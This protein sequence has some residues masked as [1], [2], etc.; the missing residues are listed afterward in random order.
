[1]K[2]HKC[3]NRILVTLAFFIA[4]SNSF[5]LNCE[6]DK[7]GW[8]D[9]IG[10]AFTCKAKNLNITQPKTL[11]TLLKAQPHPAGESNDNVNTFLIFE[12]ICDYFP[13]GIEK[14][15]KNLE[16][17][18]V[19]KSG[20]KRITKSD[21]KPF[22]KLK[23]ISLY[24]NELTT[25]ES[26]LFMYNPKLKLISVFNNKLKHVYP[27]ILDGLEH[28][29]RVYFSSNPCF[30]EDGVNPEK[31]EQLKCKLI[32]SCPVTEEMIQYAEIENEK[33]KI[34]AENDK[35]KESL[36]A[37]AKN[38]IVVKRKFEKSQENYILLK[39]QSSTPNAFICA[40]L[41][42]DLATCESEKM[43]LREL[44]QE[45]EV[46]ELVCDVPVNSGGNECI[47]SDL[48][49]L[50][51]HIK[52]VNIRRK[53]KRLLSFESMNELLIVDQ[54]TLFLPLNISKFLPRLAQL[55]VTRSELITINEE[56]FIGLNDLI[57][58]D[59]SQ[60]QLTEVK[61]ENFE[62]LVKLQKLD[63]SGN[64]IDFIGKRA[65]NSLVNLVELRLNDNKLTILGSKFF[66]HNKNLK[67][68]M[69]H[70]NQLN[71]IASNFL[72]T[73][74]SHL[75]NLDMSNN[76]CIDLKYPDVLLEYLT[77]HFTTKCIVEIDFE[78]RFES[79]FDY[80]CHAENVF[81]ET[82]NV[83]VV[84]II[85]EHRLNLSNKDVTALKIVNQTLEVIPYNLGN[86]LPNLQSV[87]IESS[88]LS[89]I[90]KENFEGL[91]NIKQLTIKGN[92][93]K[94]IVDATF[95]GFTQLQVLDLSFNCIATLAE[96]IFENLTTLKTLNLSHNQLT[97]L[98]AWMIPA[99]NA[100]EN[101]ICSQNQLT[102]IDPRL[103]RRLKSVRLLDFEDNKCIN[104]KFDES[105]HSERKVME[106]FGEAA[107]KC[108]D[109]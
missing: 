11:I 44:I 13:I 31:V 28:L 106:M 105:Q 40:S 35:L 39:K 71:Q 20:L 102:S 64:K 58:L 78:C 50:K 21:L 76:V 73:W 97:S 34:E 72:D 22:Y 53:D 14:Y 25:L 68:L 57:H 41:K 74:S 36:D 61:S 9:I 60:N 33:L 49:I 93:L 42:L 103:I 63:L 91:R 98:N 29:E 17:I 46:V 94:E 88:R 89:E 66:E 95:E 19:Q 59:L 56:A 99:R 48:K 77:R 12:Q 52:I 75:E 3:L 65:F 38:Y 69:L 80:F 81:I 45:L 7:V 90:R 62:A 55:T 6:Y 16:G 18:A 30:N 24:G 109:D 70:N 5:E 15:F 37:A 104:S 1:M 51:P 43:E 8:D 67:I 47:T 100:I 101:F 107:F 86:L 108:F 2:S 26:N 32:E 84:R 23:S 96:R 82:R 4:L 87:F 85:G 83:K 27:N 79:Q 54:Q 10:A 92:N